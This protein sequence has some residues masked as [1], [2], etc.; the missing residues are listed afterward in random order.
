VASGT[1]QGQSQESPAS[2]PIRLASPGLRFRFPVHRFPTAG[3]YNIEHAA[4]GF[5]DIFH[6][7]VDSLALRITARK[8]GH[9][10]PKPT[11]RFLMDNDCVLVHTQFSRGFAEAGSRNARPR[12]EQLFFTPDIV[13]RGIVE[14]RAP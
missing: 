8:S 7:F 2:R 6:Q 3:L 4:Y 10:S 11:L 12:N 5:A 14:Y 13:E 9:L 1:R